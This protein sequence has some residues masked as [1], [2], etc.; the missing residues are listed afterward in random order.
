MPSISPLIVRVI[1][2]VE[3]NP[4]RPRHGRKPARSR[5]GTRIRGS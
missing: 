5:F 3:S 4:R 2:S 1:D